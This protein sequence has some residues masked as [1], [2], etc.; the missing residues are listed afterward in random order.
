MLAAGRVPCYFI[1]CF[2]LLEATPQTRK[3]AM[4]YLLDAPPAAEGQNHHQPRK[5]G[6]TD[7]V[8]AGVT[9]VPSGNALTATTTV[10]SLDR[11]IYKR[12]VAEESKTV[13]SWDGY[14][15]IDKNAETVELFTENRPKWRGIFSSRFMEK[16]TVNNFAVVL[17][18]V[19]NQGSQTWIW[20]VNPKQFG[21]AVGSGDTTTFGFRYNFDNDPRKKPTRKQREAL[22]DAVFMA[23]PADAK[24]L[25]PQLE[26][27][28]QMRN[29][30]VTRYPI[31][32]IVAVSLALFVGLF[33]LVGIFFAVLIE[34]KVRRAIKQKRGHE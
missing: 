8:A 3:V 22:L 7:V 20:V 1:L 18:L 5:L 30:S 34:V 16:L 31:L 28:L 12:D 14:A 6:V 10:Y 23:L 15:L 21:N 29:D 2:L 19:K 13:L 32:S 4:G 17:V 25:C 33:S 24:F 9:T 27:R 11:Q 26:K